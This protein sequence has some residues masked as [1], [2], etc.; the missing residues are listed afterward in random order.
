MRST[1]L[2]AYFSLILSSGM[3]VLAQTEKAVCLPQHMDER[4]RH[5]LQIPEGGRSLHGNAEVET[6]RFW[7]KPRPWCH[8]S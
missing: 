3:G 7:N 2:L 5:L 8:R 4:V 1:I 6:K